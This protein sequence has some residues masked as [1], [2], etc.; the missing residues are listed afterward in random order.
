MAKYTI[1]TDGGCRP[2]PGNGAYAAIII[3]NETG[4]IEFIRGYRENATNNQMELAAVGMAL[5]HL[6]KK[7]EFRIS[8]QIVIDSNYVFEGATKWLPGWIRRGWQTAAKKPVKNA[9]IWK[10]LRPLMLDFAIDWRRIDGHSGNKY[11][12]LADAICT[13]LITN[14]GIEANCVVQEIA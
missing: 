12:E 14:E 8:I 4:E 3:N 2:N 5:I 6:K 9:K 10:W 1:Y 11:N 7:G 13:D